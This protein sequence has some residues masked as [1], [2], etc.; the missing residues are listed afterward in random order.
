[1]TPTL[2]T[3]DRK[4]TQKKSVLPQTL[5]VEDE[6]ISR[7]ITR[8]FLKGICDVDFAENGEVGY[9]MAKKKKYDIIFMD[10]GLGR[11]MNGMQTSQKIKQLDQY[12]NTPIVALTAYAMKGDREEF[13]ANGCSHYISRPVDKH[14][15]IQL[16]Q[17]ILS[18]L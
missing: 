11:G 7:V 14:K 1:M 8:M 5:L 4:E 15:L 3:E 18:Q 9:E 12:K 10:I 16:V 2:T 6:E 13:L 17:D